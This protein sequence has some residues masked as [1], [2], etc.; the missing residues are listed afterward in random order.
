MWT[1]IS[2]DRWVM[3]QPDGSSN[4]LLATGGRLLELHVNRDAATVH[5]YTGKVSDDTAPLAGSAYQRTTSRP[6]LA[7]A[8]ADTVWVALEAIADESSADQVVNR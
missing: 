2:D 7:G 1:M 4:Y 3:E 8:D 5:E 6:E